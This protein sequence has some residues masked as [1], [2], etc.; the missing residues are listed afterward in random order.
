MILVKGYQDNHG[1]ALNVLRALE[2][3][4][5]DLKKFEIR[6]VSASP[7]VE[8]EVERMRFENGWDIK[9]VSKQ[10]QKEIHN[11]L[12]HSR[13]YI[14]LSISDGLSTMMVEAM[15]FGAFPIQSLNSGAPTFLVHGTSGFIVNP[16]DLLTIS[17]SIDEAITN[18]ELV[19]S[20]V[21]VNRDQ[22]KRK[23]DLGRGLEVLKNIYS[24]LKYK[25]IKIEK[26]S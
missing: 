23:F 16:W 15:Q 22:L 3:V 5:S 13:T 17:Q 14:G 21:A 18:D 20:A 8:I 4:K 1:R 10:N 25:L 11:L 2:L 6:V 9:C 24:D 7:A 26:F 12:R 19:D